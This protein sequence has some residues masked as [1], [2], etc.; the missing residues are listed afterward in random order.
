MDKLSA[1]PRRRLCVSWWTLLVGEVKDT[2]TWI[3]NRSFFYGALCE[4]SFFIRL[5]GEQWAMVELLLIK[6]RLF[7]SNCVFNIKSF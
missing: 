6:I 5:Q 7:D 4:A 2:R 3:C 1:P